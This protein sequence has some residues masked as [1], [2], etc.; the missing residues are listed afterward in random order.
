MHSRV[1]FEVGRSARRL[2]TW[3][4]ATVRTVTILVLVV[5]VLGLRL[6]YLLAE[7]RTAENRTAQNQHAAV[8]HGSITEPQ[9]KSADSSQAEL[10]RAYMNC[11]IEVDKTM[12]VLAGNSNIKAVRAE[13]Q[14]QRAFCENRKRDCLSKIDSAE[15]RTFI[16]EFQRTELVEDTTRRAK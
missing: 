1:S 4:K 6:R 10:S 7:N 11:L 14:S 15:C 8:P 13:S 12:S 2:Q 3:A 16:S 9:S 5:V